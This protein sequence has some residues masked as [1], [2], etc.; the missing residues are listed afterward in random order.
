[1]KSKFCFLNCIKS[2]PF[3]SSMTVPKAPSAKP[4]TQLMSA[5]PRGWEVFKIFS[6]SATSSHPLGR[7]QAM[8]E[9]DEDLLPFSTVEEERAGGSRKKVLEDRTVSRGN[10][11]QINV[12]VHPYIA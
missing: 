8:K 6:P 10:F 11:P 9:P 2:L 5:E 7:W 12:Y 4:A 3:L 1:M